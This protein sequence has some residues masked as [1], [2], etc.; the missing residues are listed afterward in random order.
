MKM[1]K[2]SCTGVLVGIVTAASLFAMPLKAY[3]QD[4]VTALRAAIFEPAA[5]APATAGLPVGAEPM[6]SACKA[7]TPFCTCAAMQCSQR[8]SPRTGT[9]TNCSATLGTYTCTCGGGGIS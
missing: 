1:T 9:V 2:M 3:P 5:T 4:E 8:C 7:G 6:V